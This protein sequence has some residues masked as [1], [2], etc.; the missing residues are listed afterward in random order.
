MGSKFDADSHVDVGADL[1]DAVLVPGDEALPALGGEFRRA[2]EPVRVELT[3]SQGSS[4]GLAALRDFDPLLVG[5]GSGSTKLKLSITSP[6]V[7]QTR[8]FG[9]PMRRF[10]DRAAVVRSPTPATSPG[11]AS[12]STTADTIYSVRAN[13]PNSLRAAFT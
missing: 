7:P 8:T 5:S 1:L 3:D 6:H 12:Y 9:A 2:I 10:A 4:Q 11:H 13:S